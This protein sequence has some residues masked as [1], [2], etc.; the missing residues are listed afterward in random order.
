MRLRASFVVS[1]GLLVLLCL[2][3]PGSLLAGSVTVYTNQ[4]SFD[5]ATSGLTN[6]DFNGIAAPGSYVAYGAG[7]LTLSGVT[8][9]GNGSMFV[10]DPAY[11]GFPYTGGGFLTSDYSN[12]DI[13]NA[14]L[15]LVTAVG[16]DFGSLFS[17]GATF[18]VTLG[19]QTFIVSTT[20]STESGTLGFV[21][22]T[23][24]TP[25][26]SVTLS[27][28]DSPGYNAIDN[29]TFGSNVATTP[30]PSSLLL[31]ATSLLGLVPF[32]RKLFGL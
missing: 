16:F 6:I 14:A 10:I 3:L 17:G 29:F 4:A 18:D 20:G 5:A 27:M 2:M 32:R 1:I 9:T 13:I 22:F 21:G 19:S 23:S 8:F 7:P 15:G 11:Y 12:P 24:S 31:F 30:E 25:F 26:S 28:P